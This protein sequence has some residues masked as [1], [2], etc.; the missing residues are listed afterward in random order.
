[1]A[2]K[3]RRL[4]PLRH[5]AAYAMG[6][7]AF[8]LVAF[9]VF[10]S[11]RPPAP[12]PALV[13]CRARYDS[14]RTLRDTLVVDQHVVGGVPQRRNSLPTRCEDLRRSRDWNPGRSGIPR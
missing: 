11:R 1:M 4:Q 13:E 14:A 3:P 9:I 10:T 12:V 8:G 6:A 2:H 7:L 5:A